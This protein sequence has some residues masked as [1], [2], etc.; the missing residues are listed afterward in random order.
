MDFTRPPL[1]LDT[2]VNH[3]YEVSWLSIRRNR[4]VANMSSAS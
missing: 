2:V 3:L 1:S 4:L